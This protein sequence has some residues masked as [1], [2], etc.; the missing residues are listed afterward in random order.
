MRLVR[1]KNGREPEVMK[2]LPEMTIIELPH[3][4]RAMVFEMSGDIHNVPPEAQYSLTSDRMRWICASIVRNIS[5]VN[6]GV[7]TT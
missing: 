4:F 6:I 7:T 2:T 1:I 3:N 5:L